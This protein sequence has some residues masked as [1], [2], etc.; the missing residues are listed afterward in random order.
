MEDMDLKQKENFLI[1]KK[2]INKYIN[3]LEIKHKYDL[4]KLLLFQNINFVQ[5]SNGIYVDYT[6]LSNEIM[7]IMY[8]FIVTHI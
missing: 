2:Y 1:K 4:V 7:E 5:T 8:N 3:L 6:K